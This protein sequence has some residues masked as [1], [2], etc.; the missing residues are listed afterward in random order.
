MV[1]VIRRS[2]GRDVALMSSVLTSPHISLILSS[3]DMISPT[4]AIISVSAQR[5]EVKV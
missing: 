2:I 5:F 4:A 3:A 1:V